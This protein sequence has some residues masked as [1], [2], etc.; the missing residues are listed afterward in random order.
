MTCTHD[1]NRVCDRCAGH[2][3]TTLNH[4]TQTIQGA[5]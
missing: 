2:W 4:L 1:T 5:R 3:L